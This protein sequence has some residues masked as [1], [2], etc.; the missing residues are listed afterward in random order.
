ME[1]NHLSPGYEPSGITVSPPRTCSVLLSALSLSA[2]G[3][4]GAIDLCCLGGSPDSP[5]LPDRDFCGLVA[6]SRM[7]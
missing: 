3:V 7:R 4:G 6:L 5:A 2:H 1:S